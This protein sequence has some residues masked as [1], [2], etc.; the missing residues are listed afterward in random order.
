[1]RK[2][3]LHAKPA[4]RGAARTRTV[5]A[6]RMGIRAARPAAASGKPNHNKPETGKIDWGSVKRIEDIRS[7]AEVPVSDRLIDQ[8]I[9]QDRGI[10]IIKKAS[11]QKRNVLLIGTPGTG[12]SMLAQSMAE[13]M[14]VQQLEDIL[15]IVNKE[16]ENQPKVKTVKAGEG[17]K[18]ILQ[19]RLSG[20]LA[21][22]NTNMMMIAFMIFATFVVLYFMPKYFDNVIVAAMLIGLFLMS[23]ALMFAMQLSRGRLIEA[24]SAKMIVDN[25]GK[26]IAPFVDATGARAGA[27]LGDVKHDPF[28]SLPA[29]SR[30]LL[31]PHG[32]E[33]PEALWEKMAS[34]YPER[35]ERREKGYEAIALPKKEKIFALGYRNGRIVKSRVLSVNRRPYKGKIVELKAGKRRVRLTPEHAVV[36]RKRS[37][38]AKGVR[39]G[40][41]LIVAA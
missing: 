35:I 41:S 32:Y 2:A 7:T 1:M 12:K 23:A 11:A 29:D 39:K 24:E 33:S 5:K 9:G 28:Q 10:E 16:D 20:R 21:G 15:I 14:T 22:S 40:T 19:E 38:G 3:R 37:V 30:V 26:T 34:K 6:A 27:L 17:K 25:A 31:N 36:T 8:V 4:G 13:L 18:I